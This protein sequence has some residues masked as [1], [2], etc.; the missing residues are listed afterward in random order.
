[1]FT[2]PKSAMADWAKKAEKVIVI[3]GC[4]MRCHGRIMKNIIDK[5]NMIQ[6]DA[7]SIYNKKNK[8]T[9]IMLYDEIPEEER[10]N[11]AQ[12]VADKVL[13]TLKEKMASRPEPTST[14]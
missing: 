6:F 13:A 14:E 8:Y 12:Q 7:L 11:L 1:M 10:K 5:N 4:F 2:A 9:D 3:D